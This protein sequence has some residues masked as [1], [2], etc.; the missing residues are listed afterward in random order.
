M[1][2]CHIQY[3]EHANKCVEDLLSAQD[4]EK[5]DEWMHQDSEFEESLIDGVLKSHRK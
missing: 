1:Y 4:H 2:L 5:A 3:H